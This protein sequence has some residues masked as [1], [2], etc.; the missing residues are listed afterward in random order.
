MSLVIDQIGQLNSH[1]IGFKTRK[2]S[3]YLA[4]RLVTFVA[5]VPS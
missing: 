5:F 3:C 4:V 1:F 2:L